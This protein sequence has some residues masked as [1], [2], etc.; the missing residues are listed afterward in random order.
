[1]RGKAI[2]HASDSVLTGSGKAERVAE[3]RW[4]RGL[5]ARLAVILVLAA[6]ITVAVA[7]HLGQRQ[8][9]IVVVDVLPGADPAI[10]AVVHEATEVVETL[11]ERVPDQANSWHVLGSFYYE[12]GKLDASVECWE[13]CLQ[14][15]P[16][17]AEGH[18]WLGVA[19]RDRGRND[20]AVEW[21]RKALRGAPGETQVSVHLAQTLIDLGDMQEA[22]KVLEENRAAYPQSLASCVL[23]G[24]I[25]VQ[26]EQYDKAKQDFERAIQMSPGYTAAYYGLAKACAGLGQTADSKRYLQKFKELKTR[27][28]QAHR[29]WLKT[30]DDLPRVQQNVSGI[31][32]A[33]SK[34]YLAQGDTETAERLL[35]RAIELGVSQPE[36]HQVL[37]WLYERQ[38]RMREAQDVLSRGRE[39]NPGDIGIHLRAGTL[40][41][42]QGKFDAAEQAFE[43]AMRIMPYLGGGYAALAQFYLTSNRKLEEAKKLAAKAIELEP[44][45]KHY[46]LLGLICQRLGDLGGARA[47]IGQA[48][49]FCPANPE[50]RQAYELVR[51]HKAE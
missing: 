32:T 12:F 31:L 11:I 23:L 5:P 21:F 34:V 3:S 6:G 33:A 38:G 39:A 17:F 9:E 40:L 14:L 43:D 28:E 13:K 27:D 46:F 44:L 20:E 16:D 25:Y 37:A 45:A 50:Y 7:L 47:A 26:L 22:I 19:A 15:A 8:R 2:S 51:N 10:A 24:E 35:L 42:K 48:V 18:Y 36:C 49:A 41:A 29:D 1:M 30:G 4:Q